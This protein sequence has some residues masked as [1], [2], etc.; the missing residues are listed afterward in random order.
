MRMTDLRAGWTI[1]GNDGNHVGT[2]R[3]VGQNYVLVSTGRLSEDLYVPA[4]AIGNVESETV[5]L[6]VTARDAG[7]MGWAQPPRNEDPLDEHE[8]DLHRHI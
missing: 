3:D 4:S 2:I 1:V 8:S 6:N 5:H 7:S